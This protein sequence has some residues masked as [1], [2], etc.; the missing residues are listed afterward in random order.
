MAENNSSAPLKT[1]E[2]AYPALPAPVSEQFQGNDDGWY[3]F[4]DARHEQATMRSREWPIRE[5]FTAEQMRAYAAQAVAAQAPTGNWINADDVSRLARDLD[6][7][8]HGEDGAASQASLCDV[9]GLVKEAAQQLGRPILAAQAAPAAVAVPEITDAMVDAYLAEQRR[10]VEEAD[11]FGR[12]NIGGLHTNTVR[13]ACRNGL[14]AALATPALPATEPARAAVGLTDALRDLIEAIE[15]TPLGIRQIKALERARAAIKTEGEIPATEDSSAGDLSAP[16]DAEIIALNDGERFFSTSESRFGK[17]VNPHT[18]YHTGEPGYLQF[19]RAVLARWG[20]ATQAQAE[21]Q[22]EPV[23][24]VALTVK[25]PNASDAWLPHKIIYASLTWLDANPVGTKLYAAPQAQPA[26]QQRVQPWMMECFGPEISADRIERNHRFLEEALELVQATGCTQ[27]EAHQLVDYVFG[28]PVGEPAQE[29]GGVM[30]T[31]AALCLAN[32]LDMHQ[33][34]ETELARVWIKVEAIRAKQAA[35]PKHSPL[36]QAQP[37]DAW[38]HPTGRLYTYAKQPNN[39]DA[40]RIGEAC[41]AAQPGGDPI[42]Q[43]LSLLQKL[44]DK[45]YGIFTIDAAM[46]AAQEGGNAAK[47]A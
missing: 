12:S 11:R 7:A 31:L 3:G 18:Q 47:E 13:D 33:A 8:L 9:V 16:T 22:A 44:Q 14:R 36:P 17:E 20:S 29:V 34:G 10:T 27:S 26:F 15:Y 5:L 38:A 35:K 21:V 4:M 23:A 41:H 37:A 2:G 1:A 46:A 24:E 30:V 42:D 25:P 43:G 39:Q 32:G 45:G 6:V 19:A 40:W 28:R